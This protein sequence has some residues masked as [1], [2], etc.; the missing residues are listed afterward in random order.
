MAQIVDSGIL[1]DPAYRELVDGLE[2]II[3]DAG[4]MG[5]TDVSV[6]MRKLSNDIKVIAKSSVKKSEVG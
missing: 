5:M 6:E 1:F 4:D 3:H 2:E